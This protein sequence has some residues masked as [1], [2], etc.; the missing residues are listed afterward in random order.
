MMQIAS[1]IAQSSAL[2]LVG[3]A[4][5]AT[6]SEGGPKA[7]VPG[8]GF[9]FNRSLLKRP[10][11]SR[12]LRLNSPGP[13]RTVASPGIY[14]SW[15]LLVRR[16]ERDKSDESEEQDRWIRRW[17]EDG[18]GKEGEEEERQKIPLGSWVAQLH[19]EV[20]QELVLM[21]GLARLSHRHQSTRILKI[22]LYTDRK[23]VV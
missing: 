9:S 1:A 5:L 17:M 12:F 6:A 23:S 18:R 4:A 3:V 16:M 7:A 22:Y 10:V 19:E 13:K 15:A 8:R 2:G 21:G 14:F 11:A 20:W